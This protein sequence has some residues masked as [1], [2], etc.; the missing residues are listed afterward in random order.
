M[1]NT[2][3]IHIKQLKNHPI[4]NDFIYPSKD[5]TK[6]LKFDEWFDEWSDEFFIDWFDEFLSEIVVVKKSKYLK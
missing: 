4:S 2:K 6:D 3:R 5:G 1:N